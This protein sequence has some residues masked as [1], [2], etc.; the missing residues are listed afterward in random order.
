[1][2]AIPEKNLMETILRVREIANQAYWWWMIWFCAIYG[3]AILVPLTATGLATFDKVGVRGMAA[4]ALASAFS[5]A[6]IFLLD[7]R[8]R[9]ARVDLAF[10]DLAWIARIDAVINPEDPRLL[11]RVQA[12][13]S[14]AA[15][16]LDS[17]EAAALASSLHDLEASQE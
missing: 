2:V 13:L 10:N 9:L 4:L 8:A 15:R 17:T 1:M 6:L 16:Y 14:H 3:A 5:I 11:R 12:R 7:P